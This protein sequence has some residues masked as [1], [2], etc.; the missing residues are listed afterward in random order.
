M[1]AKNRGPT[2]DPTG[3]QGWPSTQPVDHQMSTSRLPGKHFLRMLVP[4]QRTTGWGGRG[5]GGRGGEEEE[6]EEDELLLLELLELDEELEALAAAAAAFA[7]AAAAAAAAEE[8]NE[9][10][11]DEEEEDEE[12]EEEEE[13]DDDELLEL[14]ELEEEDADDMSQIFHLPGRQRGEKERERE[15]V[16]EWGPPSNVTFPLETKRSSRIRPFLPP[17]LATQPK[18]VWSLCFS[19]SLALTHTHTR[20]LSHTQK[21]TP[22]AE[23]KSHLPPI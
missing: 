3:T 23:P 22:D 17:C 1:P 2:V 6:E 14:L 13:E 19:L 21:H 20:H 10:E 8:E 9:E 11:E 12:E 4:A 15:R 18:W 7:I 16:S 5:R